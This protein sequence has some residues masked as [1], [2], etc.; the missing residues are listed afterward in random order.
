MSETKDPAEIFGEALNDGLIAVVDTERFKKARQTLLDSLWDDI[1]Y[2][3]IDNMPEALEMLVRDMADRAV[4]AM[5]KGQ[6][7]E[8]RRYLHLDGWTGRDR[9]HQVIHG[10]LHEPQTMEL[11]AQVA[12]A[13]ENLLRDERILD[14][15]DQVASLVNTVNAKDAEIERLRYRL[16]Y[17]NTEAT[18]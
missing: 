13:N 11:R 5:L 8:V 12:R 6:P 16:R 14:L 18:Q 9:D 3:I 10:K 2:S 17:G 15:E 4:N 7:K 1:Q